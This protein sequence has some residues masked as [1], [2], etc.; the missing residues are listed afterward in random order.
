M[1]S[2]EEMQLFV[3]R[4]PPSQRNKECKWFVEHLQTSK[5]NHLQKVLY[6]D[7]CRQRLKCFE[8]R[9]LK[10]W[11]MF[12]LH[13]LKL[14]VC[15]QKIN[16]KLPGWCLKASLKNLQE[17]DRTTLWALNRW[18]PTTKTTSVNKAWWRYSLNAAN[19]TV[20][21]KSNKNIVKV[22]KMLLSTDTTW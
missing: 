16:H 11:H 13:I 7:R 12:S 15:Q 2:A 1:L 3:E 5:T 17:E 19:T 8:F 14:F 21:W 20:C 22:G 18:W 9:I 4:Y 10:L 6:S